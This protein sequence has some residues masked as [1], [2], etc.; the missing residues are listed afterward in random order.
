MWVSKHVTDL[1]A[2]IYFF[3]IMRVRAIASG[4]GIDREGYVPLRKEILALLSQARNDVIIKD[5]DQERAW[6]GW[7][8]LKSREFDAAVA[9][10][11]DRDWLSGDW[12]K[13]IV[14][15]VDSTRGGDADLT[16]EGGEDSGAQVPARRADTMLQEK[17]DFISEARRSDYT[18]WKNDALSRINQALAT[19][20]AMEVDA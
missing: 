14:D 16:D 1:V 8:E 6:D 10:V 7:K 4:A 5:I 17:Y 20:G 13:G 3:V 12:Y 9:H 11:N 15:V 18:A 2:A 19:N